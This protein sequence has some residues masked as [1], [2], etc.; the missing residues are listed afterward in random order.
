MAAVADRGP[1]SATR[2]QKC[3]NPRQNSHI[4]IIIDELARFDADSVAMCSLI[5]ADLRGIT[6]VRA[7]GR[8][9]LA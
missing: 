2:L 9:L 3:V 7:S 6:R 1:A 8:V 5:V 4:V